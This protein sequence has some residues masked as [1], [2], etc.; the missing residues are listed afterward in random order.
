MSKERGVSNW[1]REAGYH[2][3]TV[4]VTGNR[5]KRV[6]YYDPEGFDMMFAEYW[7]SFYEKLCTLPDPQIP[8]KKKET[9]NGDE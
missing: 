1:S 5:A 9:E 8:V 2:E 3:C 6:H 7:K 4:S